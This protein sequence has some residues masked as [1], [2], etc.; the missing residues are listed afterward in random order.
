[1]YCLGA[2]SVGEFL[3]FA[4]LWIWV[5][6]FLRGSL[7]IFQFI[8]LTSLSSVGPGDFSLQG[9]QVIRFKVGVGSSPV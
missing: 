4:G 7:W 6:C 2:C 5:T 3:F 8:Y 9:I 1:M